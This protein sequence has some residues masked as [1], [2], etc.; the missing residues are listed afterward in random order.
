MAKRTVLYSALGVLGLLI[1]GYL[2]L[3]AF[4]GRTVASNTTVGGV[5]VAGQTRD[6]ALQKL[7]SELGGQASDDISLKT[8]EKT[9]SLDPS[10][11]GITAEFE[12]SVDRLT[13]FTLDPTVLY[14]R[15]FGG[16]AH[17][18]GLSIDDQKFASAA[19]A[20]AKELSV[21]PTNATVSVKDGTAASTTATDGVEVSADM[22]KKALQ[23]SWPSTASTVN[24]EGTTTSPQVST[25][26]A[27]SA[28]THLA[29]P[30]VEGPVKLTVT[31][32]EDG[33]ETLTVPASTIASAVSFPV[34]DG[35]LTREFDGKT[36][37][38]A[39]VSEDSTIGV[40]AKD[41]SFT[42]SDGKAKV[43]PSTDGTSISE[44]GVKKAVDEAV[45]SDRRTADLPLSVQKASFT[46]EDA[47]KATFDEVVSEFATPYNSESAR[48]TNL[49][50]ASKKVSGTV[51][52]PGEKFSL[53]DTL[54]MRTAANGY[55]PAGVIES[56]QMKLD[57]GG[58]VSQVSTTLFN[59]A[60]F[61]GFELNEHKAH[62]R[63]ISRYPEGRESTLDFSSIDLQFTNNSKTPVLMSMYLKGGKVHAK[64]YG[65]KTVEV[66]SS[67]S[68]RFNYTSPG[69][70][71]ESGASCKP[72]S[73]ASGWSVTI[74]REIKEISSGRL[75]RDQFTTVYNPVQGISCG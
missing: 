2:A 53:N 41:A 43:V 13:G 24:V 60:Y 51:L 35:K 26:D 9:A 34:R 55:R 38:S 68:G 58:G 25:E 73:P 59:A 62:S 29:D 1:A 54:G 21:Q 18:V 31:G 7:R 48:D 75:T 19:G 37:R 17:E 39:I 23:D 14:Q 64:M 32:G 42:F 45:G 57:Y 74:K 22:L 52:Q 28:K 6:G 15:I 10:S 71:K 27:S 12:A 44:E 40:A 66:K 61:A 3:A 63:Y 72:Q 16:S 56:G 4:T 30:V 5:D 70:R 8:G 67:K 20:A 65:V 47:K 49:R 36:L 46:T 50:V 11:A 33:D 69:S